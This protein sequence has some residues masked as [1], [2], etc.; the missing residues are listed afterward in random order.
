M[1]KQIHIVV[2]GNVQGVGFR[3]WIRHIAGKLDVTGTV[4]NLDDGSVEIIAQG[5]E[6]ILAHIISAAK[7]GPPLSEVADVIVEWQKPSEKFVAF[8]ILR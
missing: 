1:T 8:E 6:D 3:W 2:I 7:D 4:Q 5:N